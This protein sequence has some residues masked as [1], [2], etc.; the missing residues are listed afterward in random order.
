MIYSSLL[1]A[2][3]TRRQALHSLATLGTVA[4]GAGTLTACAA[5]EQPAGRRRRQAIDFNDSAQSLRAFLKLTGDLDPSVETVGWF[6]GDLFAVLGD[7]KPLRK[8]IGIEGFGVLRVSPQPDGT[9]RVFNRELAFYKDPDTGEFI[10]EWTNPLTG[11]LCQSPPLHNL[12][13]NAEVAPVTRMDFDG[14]L[15]DIPFRA[16]WTIQRDNVLSLFELHAAVPNPMSPEQ[17]PRESAGPVIRITEVFQRSAKLAE[18]ED[19]DSTSTDFQGTWTRLGPW[20]PWMLMDQA[21][22]HLLYR[23]FMDKTGTADQLPR[24]LRELAERRYPEYF[25]APGDETW[26]QHND[27]S[28]GVYMAENEPKPPR[29]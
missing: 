21:P 18:L 11:E 22:G 28:F 5:P 13:V 12:V 9:Y 1:N 14:T 19:P 7:D 8:M 24:A 4:A 16:P 27:S 26:G 25:R 10:D 17:W 23:T 6:G 29:E 15:V 2:R 20:M 3:S